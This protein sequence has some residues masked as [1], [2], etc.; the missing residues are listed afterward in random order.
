MTYEDGERRPIWKASH[1]TTDLD[2]L[3]WFF[4]RPDVPYHGL[5]TVPG[6]DRF[7]VLDV[8]NKPGQDGF[9]Q[10]RQREQRDRSLL[11]PRLGTP[12]VRTG[13]GGA[14]F[15]MLP[16]RRLS[17]HADAKRTNMIGGQP[18]VELFVRDYALTL[19]PTRYPGGLPYRWINSPFANPL[20]EVPEALVKLY[21]SPPEPAPERDDGSMQVRDFR[22]GLGGSLQA[23]LGGS[24]GGRGVMS[25]D[26][27]CAKIRNIGSGNQYRYLFGIVCAYAKGRGGDITQNELMALVNAG[28]SMPQGKDKPWTEKQ[29]Y[30]NV[31]R[32]VLKV[33]GS[34]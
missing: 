34:L 26:E 24:Y 13:G 18:G 14:H 1:A 3:A 30:T 4:Q 8:E 33:K 16:D 11:F 2:R 28:L 10:L 6:P 21:L 25:L 15:Y 23:P 9:A 17:R 19:P 12:E 22:S 5:A 7:A 32:A 20:A 27:A 31:T 29:V